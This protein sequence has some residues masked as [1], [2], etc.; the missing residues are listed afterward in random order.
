MTMRKILL[1][2]TL[3]LGFLAAA[4][5]GSGS[6]GGQSHANGYAPAQAPPANSATAGAKVALGNT[7]F[8]MALVNAQGHSLY[9]FKKDGKNMSSCS[10]SCAAAWPPLVTQGA[11]Q[12]GSGVTAAK[13]GTIMRKDGKTQVT[14]AGQPLYTYAADSKPGD[15]TGQDSK[16][17]GAAW[18][19]V[20]ANGK[21]IGA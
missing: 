20:A 15:V 11:P 10:G 16:A 21:Q 18:Y 13:L 7:K 1:S 12:A 6:G 19:L 14:Y 2:G 17:F 4:C 9:L 5:G 8:G 3:A